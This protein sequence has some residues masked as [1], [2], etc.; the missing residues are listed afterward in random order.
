[1]QARQSDVS[2][3]SDGTGE[4][5]AGCG[6]GPSEV[7]LSTKLDGPIGAYKPRGPGLAGKSEM[8]NRPRHCQNRLPPLP[9]S[10]PPVIARPFWN[11]GPRGGS[12][13]FLGESQLLGTPRSSVLRGYPRSSLL[14]PSEY[15]RSTVEV[16]SEYQSTPFVVRRGYDSLCSVRGKPAQ[17]GSRAASPA[18][19]FVCG[20][21]SRPWCERYPPHDS[22]YPG[23]PGY[24]LSYKQVLRAVPHKTLKMGYLLTEAMKYPFS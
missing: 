14:V 8:R 9:E 17:E 3:R 6:E 10:S 23:Y 5:L 11:P 21:K 15:D 12:H 19:S 18:L 2:V 1:M 7:Y 16:P 20:A 4:R 24:R 13:N 22:E